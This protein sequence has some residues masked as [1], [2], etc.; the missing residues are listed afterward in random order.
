MTMR[1]RKVSVYLTAEIVDE[2]LIE[3]ARQKRPL[4]W[5]LEHAWALA[6]VRIAQFPSAPEVP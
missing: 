6:K 4:S 1:N 5:L 2:L 3:S